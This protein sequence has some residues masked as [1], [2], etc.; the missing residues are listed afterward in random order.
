MPA[1]RRTQSGLGVE[2]LAPPP[3]LSVGLGLFKLPRE[4]FATFVPQIQG[5]WPDPPRYSGQA[6]F[7]HVQYK[8]HNKIK[9]ARGEDLPS[10]VGA[11][12]Q[13]DVEGICCVQLPSPIY[14]SQTRRKNVQGL[15]QLES[16]KGYPT[17]GQPITAPALRCRL[18]CLWK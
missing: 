11:S 2:R 14:L 10:D 9:P 13:T 3:T 18:S 6:L 8:I 12:F 16:F 17:Y 1:V 4:A 5:S 7:W 15:R